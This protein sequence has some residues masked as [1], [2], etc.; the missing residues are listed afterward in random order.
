MI[1]K[2]KKTGIDQLNNFLYE[3]KSIDLPWWDADNKTSLEIEVRQHTDKNDYSLCVVFCPDAEGL[4]ERTIV[5]Y[6]A[7]NE[8][9]LTET[10][11]IDKEVLE[12]LQDSS[13]LEFSEDQNAYFTDSMNESKSILSHILFLV[14]DQPTV[15][16]FELDENE[17][18]E[19]KEGDTLDHFIGMMQINSE[20]ITKESINQYLAM[21]MEYEGQEYL[22]ALQEDV[23]NGQL[24][25]FTD[26][27]AVEVDKPTLDL[28]VDV[29]GSYKI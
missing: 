16:R 4:L 27:Y 28:I 5:F 2:L 25:G 17:T 21:G 15:E 12:N 29:V 20:E 24:A 22:E 9:D 7:F 3:F 10:T 1:Q 11:L 6:A 23:K 8:S 19:L 13:T 26:E 18:G 14:R